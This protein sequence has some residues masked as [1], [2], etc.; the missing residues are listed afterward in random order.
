MCEAPPPHPVRDWTHPTF[1][2]RYFQY[3]KTGRHCFAPFLRLRTRDCDQYYTI[4]TSTVFFYDFF[5]TLG[6]EVSHVFSF[7]F[8]YIYC[9]SREDQIRLARKEIMGYVGRIVCRTAS[10]DNLIV[11]GI[12]LAVRSGSTANLILSERLAQN[13]YLPVGYLFWLLYSELDRNS[14]LP[15]EI[16]LFQP[17]YSK[18]WC[19]VPPT[20]SELRFRLRNP[21][22]HA[23]Y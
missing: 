14:S 9:P 11:F 7:I 8:R 5:L 13:R 16:I 17:R 23:C 19:I 2:L 4:A 3:C 18:F 10:V 21:A 20:T 22:R 6:D 15:H 1:L 12:F